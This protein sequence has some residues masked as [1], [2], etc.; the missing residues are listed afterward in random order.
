MQAAIFVEPG[1]M[2]TQEIAKPTITAP[3]DAII[4]VVRASV[5]GSDLWW[6]RGISKR[7]GGHQTGH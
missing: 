4:R 7:E 1:K 3:N 6:Y 5:C 2:I